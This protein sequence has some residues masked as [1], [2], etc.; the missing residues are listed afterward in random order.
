L[1]IRDT[2]DP[3]VQVKQLRA[4]CFKL[5]EQLAQA[6]QQVELNRSY[7]ECFI[8]MKAGYLKMRHEYELMQRERPELPTWGELVKLA[9][10][11]GGKIFDGL[12]N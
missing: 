2:N 9:G 1:S 4:Q 8:Q 5:T 7:R 11:R 10:S 12:S 3:E 6:M